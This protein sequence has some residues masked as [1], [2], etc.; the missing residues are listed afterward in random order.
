MPV[1]NPAAENGVAA[2]NGGTPEQQ[3]QGNPVPKV[4]IPDYSKYGDFY[5]KPGRQ[6]GQ[7]KLVNPSPGGNWVCYNGV[8]SYIYV[9]NPMLP[10]S[11]MSDPATCA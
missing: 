2:D 1:G 6:P 5:Q 7:Y 9:A 4:S 11:T 8:L 3:G 10:G